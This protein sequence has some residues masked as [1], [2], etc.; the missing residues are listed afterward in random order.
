MT[1]IVG[2]RIVE[3]GV[4]V[5][6]RRYPPNRT[7]STPCRKI[8]KPASHARI[9]Y[10]THNARP[11]GEGVLLNETSNRVSY[12]GRDGESVSFPIKHYDEG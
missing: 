12:L 3:V 11:C 1:P 10:G 8:S 6:A 7:G 2:R 5:N 9:P 4:R